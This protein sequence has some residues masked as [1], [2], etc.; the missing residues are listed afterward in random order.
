MLSGIKNFFS[1]G[2]SKSPSGNDND[3]FSLDERTEDIFASADRL[4]NDLQ[5]H[6]NFVS[7]VI[8]EP[9]ST[10][11]WN[12]FIPNHISCLAQ[13]VLRSPTLGCSAKQKYIIDK[14]KTLT[15]KYFY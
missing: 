2:K 9:L 8:V 6:L 15:T 14:H 10:R 4:L 13:L 5:V 12:I 7:M 3:K 1:F 11:I